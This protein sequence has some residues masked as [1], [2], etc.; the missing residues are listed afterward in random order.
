MNVFDWIV[1]VAGA[2]AVLLG[3]AKGA[4]RI[5]FG[6]LTLVAGFFVATRFQDPVAASLVKVGI[7]TGPAAVLSWAVLYL[8]TVTAG[9]FLGWMFSRALQA[10]KLGWADRIGGASI[11]VVAGALFAAALV[12]ALAASH[13]LGPRALGGSLLA[14]YAAAL[15]D[16]GNAGVPA[17]LA[18]RYREGVEAVR[19]LW[20]A[21][22]ERTD[23]N[24]EAGAQE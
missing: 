18:R 24:P 8:G 23:R 6:L 2:L 7:G 1:V 11:G 5:S 4:A 22:R 17:G 19:V 16:L 12:H 13:D 10:A 20:R 14:P 9:G 15:A 21:E 3:F